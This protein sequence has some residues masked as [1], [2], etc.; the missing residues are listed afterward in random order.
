M[1]GILIR[2]DSHGG[3]PNNFISFIHMLD[4]TNEPF[5]FG[6]RIDYLPGGR[7]DPVEVIPPT[8]LAGPD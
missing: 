2:V 8:P 1:V 4:F 7:V 6:D 3:K 5:S